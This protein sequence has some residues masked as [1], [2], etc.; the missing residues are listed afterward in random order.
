MVGVVGSSPIAPTK[1]RKQNQSLQQKCPLTSGHFCLCGMKIMGKLMPGSVRKR[2]NISVCAAQ[3]QRG[4]S[5][6]QCLMLG[7]SGCMADRCALCSHQ[8]C[9]TAREV[10]DASFLRR[11][12]A[13]ISTLGKYSV[14]RARQVLLKSE[15]MRD[16]P[17]QAVGIPGNFDPKRKWMLSDDGEKRCSGGG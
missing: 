3:M 13:R 4:E 7:R 14:D 9:C 17:D 10:S 8:G 15:G 11:P 6:T 16:M 2:T 1:H 5:S 12:Q